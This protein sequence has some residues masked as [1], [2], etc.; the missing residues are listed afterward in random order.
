[1]PVAGAAAIGAASVAGG[2]AA[3]VGAASTTGILASAL[4]FGSSA[5]YGIGASLL[6]G[7]ASSALAPT[8]RTGIGGTTRKAPVQAG[9]QFWRRVYGR[10]QISSSLVYFVQHGSWKTQTSYALVLASHE[11]EALDQVIIGDTVVPLV[12][13]GSTSA[14]YP[15]DYLIPDPDQPAG[16]KFWR[17][18]PPRL[19]LKPF[20]GAPGQAAAPYLVSVSGGQWTSAHKLTGTAW[21]HVIQD[22]HPQVWPA[23]PP[24]IAFVVRGAKILDPRT[25]TTAY[26]ANAALVLLD[27][28]RTYLP[29]AADVLDIAS[30]AAAAN[31][32]D[33][34][35]SISGG[36]T[37]PRYEAH[38]SMTEDQAPSEAVAQ[39]LAAMAGWIW[40]GPSG[41]SVAAGAARAPVMSLGADD[42][43]GDVR[44]RLRRSRSQIANTGRV[45][46]ADAAQD[47]RP[48]ETEWIT[49]STWRAEDNQQILLHDVRLNWVTNRHQ[50]ETIARIEV[51]RTRQQVSLEASWQWKA[52]PLEPGDVVSIT[53]DR[54]GWAAK[55]FEVLRVERDLLGAVRLD[56]LEYDGSIW[57]PPAAS[58]ASAPQIGPAGP[59]PTPPSITLAIDR[60]SDSRGPMV[61]VS[62]QPAETAAEI[63]ILW[64]HDQVAYGGPGDTRVRYSDGSGPRISEQASVVVASA[65]AGSTLI[66]PVRVGYRTYV[67]A[68]WIVGQAASDW[69]TASIW[70]HADTVSLPAPRDLRVRQV[71]GG[72]IVIK[73]DAAAV[74]PV[75]WWE[76]WASRTSDD[77]STA[78]IVDTDTQGRR[79]R[80]ADVDP[81]PMWIWVRGRASDGLVTEW[82]GPVFID[83]SQKIGR[84]ASRDRVRTGD[85]EATALTEVLTVAV[86]EKNTVG[87]S[88]ETVLSWST[89]APRDELDAARRY[90]VTIAIDFDI[91]DTST[92]TG[93]DLQLQ[94]SVDSSSWSDAEVINRVWG[95][96]VPRHESALVVQTQTAGT[97]FWRLRMR[98]SGAASRVRNIRAVTTLLKG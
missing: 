61:R 21:V 78:E 34:P 96:R 36:G 87:T 2:Y 40:S 39:V 8:P 38:G 68:R 44:V 14:R 30:F 10:T 80:L 92:S 42:L 75:A 58:T 29:A 56:L 12:V 76:V 26:S 25:N 67:E 45:V 95:N 37:R 17:D 65:A 84:L 93:C 74:S 7:A 85:I 57:T 33:E 23:G 81:G 98:M 66:G 22:Y 43:A 11:I 50:A 54:Y 79:A 88:Y 91:P 77:R 83:V 32:C 5:L 53:L 46:Y 6:L 18:G 60:R 51:G 48:R 69:A 72:D 73:W 1:M 41:I 9:E 63:E 28:L 86:D 27:I 89:T 52:W 24:D 35:I 55:P 13:N 31:V 16:R 49:D 82:A 15:S 47:Y 70:A 97:V 71:S 90:A 59:S 64:R 20:L 3:S 62:W 4:S 19:A 94:N